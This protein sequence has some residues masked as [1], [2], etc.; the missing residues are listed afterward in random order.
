MT[1]STEATSIVDVL[2]SDHRAI[3]ELFTGE[4]LADPDEHGAA[5]RERLVTELVRHFVAEE[6]YLFPELRERVT[7]GAA[8]ADASFSRDRGIERQ[9]RALEKDVHPDRLPQLLADIRTA[10]ASHVSD[11]DPQFAALTAASSPQRLGELGLDALGAEQ[12]APTRPRSIAPTSAAANKVTSLVEGYID[13]VRDHYSH[14][15]VDRG[16]AP[17]PE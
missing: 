2:H 7:D 4:R 3:T 13:H 8:I 14:R 17:R 12:L 6:Q 1:D 5:L 11:Q 10:F 16:S 15:A 9:L